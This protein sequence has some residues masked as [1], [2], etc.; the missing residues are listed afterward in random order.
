VRALVQRVLRA[1]V[2]VG[3]EPVGEIGPGLF[4]LAAAGADDTDTDVAWTAGKLARLRVFADGAGRMNRSV[5]EAGGAILLVSQFTLYGDVARGNRPSFTGAAPPEAGEALLRRLA[6][7]L[8]GE[9]LRVE[10]GRFGAHMLVE[11]VNDGPVTIWLDSR[12]RSP[13]RP[14]DSVPSSG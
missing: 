7:L 8:T 14:A 10:T 12:G 13:G 3:E 1:A 2:T 5:R 6:D 4:V 11:L 9:G